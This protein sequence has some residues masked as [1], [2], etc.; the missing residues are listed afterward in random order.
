[1]AAIASETTAI[2]AAADDPHVWLEEV[3]GE[4]ALAWVKER[5]DEC[6]SDA[7]FPSAGNIKETNAYKRILG[8]LD[9]KDKIPGITRIGNDGEAP[10][11]VCVSVCVCVCVCCGALACVQ[12]CNVKQKE[13][14]ESC[15]RD[16][17]LSEQTHSAGLLPGLYI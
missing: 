17:R 14:R 11:C 7:A 15:E 16:E 8:I 4:R 1:M 10:V 12:M 2:P 13:A 6:L 9:S 5:N 3:E